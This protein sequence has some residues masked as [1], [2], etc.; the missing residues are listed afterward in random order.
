MA[1]REKVYKVWKDG[2]RIP[3]KYEQ[4]CSDLGFRPSS[5]FVQITSAGT[6]TFSIGKF[7]EV[8]ALYE[9]II[10]KGYKPSK[11]CQ[12]SFECC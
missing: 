1:A 4:I 10:N 5:G 9:A 6:I 12:R 8:K 11:G 3:M 2:E 7:E